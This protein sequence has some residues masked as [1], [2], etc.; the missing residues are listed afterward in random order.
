MK[1]IGPY[2]FEDCTKL[3]SVLLPDGVTSVGGFSHCESLESITIP[4]SVTSI[5]AYAFYCCYNLTNVTIPDSVKFIGFAAFANNNSLVF[6]HLPSSLTAISQDA[7]AYCISKKLL[8]V[9]SDSSDCYARVFDQFAPIEFQLCDG[10]HFPPHEHEYASAVTTDPTCTANGVRTYTCSICG[11]SYTESIAP[12][13]HA[14]NDGVVTKNATCTAEGEMTFICSRCYGSYTEPIEKT[15]HTALEIRTEPDCITPGSVYTVC[16]DCGE[17]LSELSVIPMLGH[18]YNAVETKAATCKET[19]IMTYTCSRCSDSYTEPIEKKPHTPKNV[20]EPATCMAD[21][22]Q[23]TQCSACEEILSEITVLPKIDHAFGEWVTVTEATMESEGL[24]ERV[25]TYGCGTKETEVLPKIPSK[26]VEDK[27][28]RISLTYPEDAYT[29]EVEL[30]IEQVFDGAAFNL[31]D[32]NSEQNVVFDITTVLDGVAVQPSGKVIVRIPVPEGFDPEKCM[33]YHVSAETNS[34]VKMNARYEDGCMV[35]ETDHFSV[36]AVAIAKTITV[37]VE[38][39][40][41]TGSTVTVK[42]AFWQWL[43]LI[44]LFGFLWY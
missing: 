20:T 19:G 26:T 14:Y 29:G 21:G 4:N 39:T 30:K 2:A 10:T 24:R 31:V 35:F 43:I 27:N 16:A 17:P 22:G 12:L 32:L 38:V 40:T 25:C 8:Y 11:K 6:V 41:E 3:K 37:T 28:S 42:Y 9:C 44:F 33:V 7:F 15:P 36:Y 1:A 18:E 23:Y 5:A 13:G 34:I